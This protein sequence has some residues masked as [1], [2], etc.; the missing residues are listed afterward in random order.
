MAVVIGW[1]EGEQKQPKPRG[2]RRRRRSFPAVDHAHQN[3]TVVE[4]RVH[5]H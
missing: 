5:G 1:T 2:E 3:S 4:L